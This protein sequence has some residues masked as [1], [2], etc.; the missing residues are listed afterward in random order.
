MSESEKKKRLEYRE[1]RKKGIFI[2]T[3]IA[4]VVALTIALSA[5]A[6]FR[7]DN[8]Y[9]V[10][11][12]ESSN[13]DYKVYLHENDYYDEEY[14]DKGQVYIASLIK[15]VVADFNYTFKLDSDAVNYDASYSLFTELLVRDKYNGKVVFEKRYD[16]TPQTRLLKS[17]DDFVNINE[18]INI[19][20]GEYNSLANNF[21][22]SYGLNSVNCSLNVVLAVNV[23]GECSDFDN[24][25][26]SSHTVS[27]NLP[28]T[29]KTVD[30]YVTT[31]V[32]YNQTN[33]IM[34][35]Q[36]SNRDIFKTIAIIATLVEVLV[37][38]VLI[39][40][41][42]MTRNY[43]INYEIKVKR[44]VVAYKSYIQK[45]LTEFCFD[46]Y[47]VLKVETF[48]EMLDIRDTVNLPILMSENNDK[49]CTTF[50][51]PTNNNLLYVHEIK[52]EDYDELYGNDN[53]SI[54]YIEE[55]TVATDTNA[56]FY[57]NTR[58]DY[59]FTA[60]L[61]LASDETRAF[62]NDIFAFVSSYG[63]KVNRSWGKERVQ[64]G[65]KTYAILSF[66][67]LKLAVS[68][69]LDPLDYEN[70]KYKLKNVANVKKFAQ[71][72][73][74]MKVT[75]MRKVRWVK[76][77]FNDMLSKDGI[78]NKNLPI[79]VKQIRAKSKNKLIAEN[80]IKKG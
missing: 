42:F 39:V 48:N 72:P 18:Q 57:G 1:K 22:G 10:N 50:M 12:T 62:Y 8:E 2:Q 76:E 71:V 21:V 78:E 63:L 65:R 28:L 35:S 4:V 53:N 15:N 11:Y 79:K 41:V 54:E 32:P 23:A 74:Q 51:I 77:L 40:F 33:T 61:H 26:L 75:S 13:V 64:L 80:L 52:V 30:V 31:S 70:T 5:L 44:L 46:G 27:L 34:C 49:T 7:I 67:G 60:K 17:T 47:Q 59:S 56:S 9:S 3:V 73:A 24:M 25:K 19:N 55:E 68:F 45:I 38:C 43:D 66:K 58:Y 36:A 14:L 37:L 69:A 6:Y 29:Q 20:Y 16:I